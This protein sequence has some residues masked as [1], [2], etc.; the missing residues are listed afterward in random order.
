MSPAD[1]FTLE[2][3]LLVGD[4]AG[5][6]NSS[7]G[8]GIHLAYLSG[9]IAGSLVAQNKVYEYPWLLWKTV[10]REIKSGRIVFWIQKRGYS[11]ADFFFKLLPKLKGGD[12]AFYN[13]WSILPEALKCG[14][15]LGFLKH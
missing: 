12:R 3:V 11:V 9:R 1:E 6:M 14:L 7:L 10:G 5:L 2:N 13:F 15:D 4:A 8:A